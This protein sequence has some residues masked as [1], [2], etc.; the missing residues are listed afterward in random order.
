MV[1]ACT[2]GTLTNMLPH[3]NAMSQSRDMTSHPVTLEYTATHF[4]VFGKT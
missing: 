4:N 1:P 2:S 3:M